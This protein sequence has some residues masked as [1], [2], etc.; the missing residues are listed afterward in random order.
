LIISLKKLFDNFLDEII[1]KGQKNFL[2]SGGLNR[3]DVSYTPHRPNSS[4]NDF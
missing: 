1:S 2:D 3:T 4:Y